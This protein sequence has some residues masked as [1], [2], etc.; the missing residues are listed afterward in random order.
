MMIFRSGLLTLLLAG[1]LATGV[2]G[3]RSG[4]LPATAQNSPVIPDHLRPYLQEYV[5]P[6]T[7]LRAGFIPYKPQIVWGEPLEVR[8]RVEDLRP[9]RPLQRGSE[10]DTSELQS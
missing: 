7:R 9:K 4:C 1:A 6:T 5:T 8:F 10:E 3:G 2:Y